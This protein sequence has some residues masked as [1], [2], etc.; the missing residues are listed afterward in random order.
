MINKKQPK[1]VLLKRGRII[2]PF[3]KKTFIGDIL[4]ENG[5]I[6]SIKKNIS[7]K[8][9]NIFKIDCKGLVV[10]H[11][12]CDIHVHFREPGREDKETLASGSMAA[13]AGGFT[14]V[15]TMPNTNPPI[16]SP[17]HIYYIKNKSSSLPIDIFPI[18]AVSLGQKGEELT[19]M[20]VMKENGAIA[21]SDDGIPIQNA[22]FMALALKYSKMT[23]LPVINHAEDIYLRNEGVMNAGPNSNNLGLKGNPSLAESV[24][25]Y[26]DLALASALGARLHIP[27]ISTK[28]SV[29]LVKLFKSKNKLITA[30]VSPHHLYFCDDD[31]VDFNTNL[32]VGP[33]I[34]SKSDRKKLIEGI[35]SGI[36]DCIATDHAPHTIEDKETTFNDAEFGMI[37]L[38]SCFGAVNKVLVKDNGMSLKS[39]IE[40]LT[41]NPRKI[42][43]INSDLFAVGEKA[44]ITIFDPN[45]K[46]TFSEK[47]IYSKSSNSP[48]IGHDLVGKIKYVFS[49]DSFF[50]L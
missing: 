8:D 39:L 47:N 13:L 4:V 41:V 24:M 21:F 19:E 28:D 50:T 14:Q 48:F 12:F 20:L 23:N 35:K 25:V 29:G 3:S 11:G 37:G 42:M 9:K 40:K 27:H 10:T 6:A 5:K 1:K 36:I 17:E 32:K 2:D 34:R 31:I 22:Q 16:D 38:E 33:P 44:Q 18:G 43:N 46:W 45:E 30:E 26:R 15:C 49:K 7:S